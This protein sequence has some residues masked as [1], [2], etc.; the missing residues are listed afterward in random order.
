MHN[1]KRKCSVFGLVVNFFFSMFD[2]KTC[3]SDSNIH[4]NSA[5]FTK[6]HQYIETVVNVYSF[7][8]YKLRIQ[9]KM[10]N[11]KIERSIC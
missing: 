11:I 5:N 1:N 7:D 8:A 9:S 3:A 10:R 2:L 6:I 4:L